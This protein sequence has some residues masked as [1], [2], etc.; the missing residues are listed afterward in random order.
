[1]LKPQPYKL[2]NTIQYYEWGMK[3]KNAFIPKLLGMKVQKGKPYAELWMGAHTNG[4]SKI[5]VEGKEIE[6]SKV[7]QQYPMETLGKRTAKRF[8]KMLAFLFKVLSANDALSIQVHPTKRQAITLHKKDPI[9]YPDANQKIEIAIALDSLTALV[10]FKPLNQILETL[11]I[12]PE[13]QDYIGEKYK[14]IYGK[15]HF[16]FISGS[17]IKML[18]RVQHDK[19]NIFR[20]A[21]IDSLTEGDKKKIFKKI[22]TLII[23][24]SILDVEGLDLVIKNLNKRISNKKRKSKI[25]KYFLVLHKKYGNDIGLLILFFLNLVHLR[26]GEAIFIKPGVPH[27]Y[28][29]GNILECMTNSDNVIRVGLTPKFKDIKTLLKV[30]NYEYG[31]PKILKGSRKGKSVIY[32]T[33]A[34][35]FEIQIFDSNRKELNFENQ[36]GPRILFVLKGATKI[37][38]KGNSK[39]RLSEFSKGESAFLPSVLANFKIIPGSS[40]FVIVSVP[41]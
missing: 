21:V 18:K 4:S 26:G 32:K 17:K 6:L 14:E 23:N 33:D 35:E 31:L 12:Y 30:L 27:A 20:R 15:R 16:E 19:S 41:K 29:K 8:S 38:F 37:L 25:D 3:G 13:I 36:S 10:G 7:I 22:F 40:Q 28:L 34:K 11:R 9:N 1:M 24:K 5:I 2:R 39:F